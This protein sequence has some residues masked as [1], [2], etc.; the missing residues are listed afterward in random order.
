MYR[1]RYLPKQKFLKPSEP[2]SPR[3]A[4]NQTD[5]EQF[6]A[7]F[8]DTYRRYELAFYRCHPAGPLPRGLMRSAYEEVA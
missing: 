1:D 4:Q 3:L 8:A 7:E 2:V 6:A 5:L